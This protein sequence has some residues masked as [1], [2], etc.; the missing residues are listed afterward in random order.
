MLSLIIKTN[1]DVFRASFMIHRFYFAIRYAK[2]VFI[3][4]FFII[5]ILSSANRL[6]KLGMG[7]F[8]SS[9]NISLQRDSVKY[10]SIIHI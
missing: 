4:P 9:L 10:I 8:K 3:M 1:S 6:P 7:I 2:L 5:H